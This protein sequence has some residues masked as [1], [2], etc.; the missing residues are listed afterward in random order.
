MR[1]A[2]RAVLPCRVRLARRF[3]ALSLFPGH[4][5]AHAAQDGG[6]GRPGCRAR[7]GWRPPIPGRGDGHERICWG[8]PDSPF[9]DRRIGKLVVRPGR[10]QEV[11]VLVQ[12]RRASQALDPGTTWGDDPDDSLGRPATRPSRMR[13]PLAPNTSESRP[14]IRMPAASRTLWI[15]FFSRA[16]S[17][18][19]LRRR[20]T[21]AGYGTG[22]AGSC[23]GTPGNWQMVVSQAL[24][25]M[26][27]LR[28]LSCLTCWAWT[29]SGWM[30]ASSRAAKGA[31][32]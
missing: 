10:S 20:L 30:P 24:S 9:E 17:P 12:A 2:R 23:S 1:V 31:S 7:S 28:P 15:R 25:W 8:K 32:Q 4:T 19:S 18:T 6:T 14:P 27:V 29:S 26:S 16:W 11:A 21:L 22:R 3:P 5:P 13:R